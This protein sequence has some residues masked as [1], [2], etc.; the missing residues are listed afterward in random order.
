LKRAL[1]SGEKHCKRVLEG[2][3]GGVIISGS[4]IVIKEELSNV[5]SV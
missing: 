3:E 4:E 1:E 5:L 2:E